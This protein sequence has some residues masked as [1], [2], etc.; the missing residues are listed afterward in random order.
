MRVMCRGWR[1]RGWCDD[2]RGLS[3]VRVAGHLFSYGTN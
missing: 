1:G 2:E 3:K